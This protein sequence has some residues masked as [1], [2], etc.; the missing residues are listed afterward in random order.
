MS[1][2]IMTVIYLD[3]FTVILCKTYHSQINA[4]GKL[5]RPFRSSPYGGEIQ[6]L[7]K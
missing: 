1:C 3:K 2:V 4:Q 6:L 7:S 5:L